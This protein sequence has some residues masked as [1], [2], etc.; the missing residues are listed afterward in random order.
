VLDRRGQSLDSLSRS[1]RHCLYNKDDHSSCL[2]RQA[3]VTNCIPKI[4]RRIGQVD[5]PDDPFGTLKPLALRQSAVH[6]P[7]SD[8]GSYGGISMTAER[9]ERRLAAIWRLKGMA[10]PMGADGIATLDA[11]NE[12]RG[13]R[14]GLMGFMKPVCPNWAH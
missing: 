2:R 7:G 4:S 12:W 6:Y 14:R 8:H 5:P 9:V 13:T 3:T 10:A 11:L 1:G